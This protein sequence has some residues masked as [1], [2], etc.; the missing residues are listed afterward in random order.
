MLLGLHGF[1]SAARWTFEQLERHLHLA[2][3]LAFHSLTSSAGAEE[4]NV[5]EA[6][7]VV[8][9]EPAPEPEPVPEPEPE[10]EFQGKDKDIVSF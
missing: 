10:L 3:I 4:D 5:A 6:E 8:A 9:E 7:P 1:Q 2:D